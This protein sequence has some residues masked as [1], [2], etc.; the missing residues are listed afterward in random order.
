MLENKDASDLNKGQGTNRFKYRSFNSRVETL[1][2]DIVRR[3]RLV[4]DD[5]DENE[6]FF[7]DAL[8][9]WKDLNL[10][11]HFKEFNK[12]ILPLSKSL[13]SIVHH[14][15][16]IVDILEKHLLVKNS[17]ALDALLD[18]VTKLAKDLEGEFYP[19]YPRMLKCMLPLVYHQDVTLLECLFNSLAYLFK[20]LSRQ[21]IPDVNDTFDQLAKLL[22]ED[23][24]TK[25]YIRHFSAEAF[26]FLMRKVRADGLKKLVSH[27]LNSLD[28]DP[29]PQYVEGL[30]MLFFECMKQVDGCLHSRAV[31]IYT[32]LYIQT[33]QFDGDADMLASSA[34]YDLLRKTTLLVLHHTQRQHFTPIIKLVL[35]QTDS[36]LEPTKPDAKHLAIDMAV[37]A[38]ITTVRKAS[39]V[40]DFKPI[41]HRIQ[42]VTKLVFTGKPKVSSSLLCDE[43]LHAVT[44][45]LCFGSL[46]VV[47]SGGRLILDH[48]ASFTSPKE[49]FGFF[50]GLAELEWSN[51]CQ[52]AL[53]FITKCAARFIKSSPRET[54]YFLAQL[55]SRNALAITPG[56]M[57]ASVNSNGLLRFPSS[58]DKPLLKL[59]ATALDWQ[60]EL[61]TLNSFDVEDESAPA[62]GLATL[63]CV[64]TVLPAI[65]LTSTRDIFDAVLNLVDTLSDTLSHMDKTDIQSTPMVLGHT[66]F[67][68]T[69]LLGQTIH[70][71]AA[72]AQQDQTLISLLA[73]RHAFWLDLLNSHSQN[74]AVIKGIYVYLDLLQS[75]DK[76][77]DHFSLANLESVYPIIKTNLRSYQRNARLYSLK[78]LA[79]FD[80][81]LMKKDNDHRLDEPCDIVDVA[82]NMES[83]VPTLTDYRDKVILIQKINLISSAGRLPDIFDDFVPLVCFGL[84]T[85]NFKP[86]WDEARKTL[87]TFADVNKD[88]YWRM[89][90]D[91][92]EKFQDDRQLV[93][94]GFTRPVME[95]CYN[96]V[97]IPKGKATKTGNISF[98]CPNLNK[99]I[100]VEDHALAIMGAKINTQGVLLFVKACDQQPDHIDFWNY[101]NLIFKTLTETPAIV[102]QR[103]R[104]LIPLFFRFL[105]T[106]YSSLLTDDDQPDD[107]DNTSQQLG[108]VS[109]SIRTVK[110]KMVAWL[111]LLATF[112]NPR[113]LFRTEEIYTVLLRLIAKGD[114]RLQA[115]ALEALFTWKDRNVKPYMDNLRN[116]VDE[117]KFRD[118]LSTLLQNRDQEAI[119]PA[120]RNGLM[121]IIMRVLYGRFIERSGK[122]HNHVKK[123]RR[124]AILSAVAAC[125]PEEMDTFIHL[126]LEAFQ[127]IL[128]L[129]GDEFNEHD[130]L[131]SFVFDNDQGLDLMRNIPWRQQQGLVIA[132]EEMIKQLGATLAPFMHRLVKVV[133]Y[134]LHFAQ[135][136]TKSDDASDDDDM[137]VDE[138]QSDNE[139]NHD[140]ADDTAAAATSSSGGINSNRSRNIRNLAL[141]RLVELF[142]IK[143]GYDF[144]PYIP[145][146]FASFI[147]PRLAHF[148]DQSQ[149][150]NGLLSLFLEW[151]TQPA[152]LPF[153]ADH[154]A[155][156]LPQVYGI[157]SAQSL[158]R[159]VLETV[160][161]ILEHLLNYCDV[162][163]NDA[164]RK[165]R[166]V[167]NHI[168]S[169]LQYFLYR[170]TQSKDD[171]RFGS[172]YLSV[173][174]IALVAR[175]APFVKDGARTVMLL[176]ILIPNLKKPTRYIPEATKKHILSIWASFLP[177][178]PDFECGSRVY[179]NHYRRASELFSSIQS[180][181][182]RA[183]LMQVFQRFVQL[184]SQ[185]LGK[186]GSLLQ[187]M[188]SYSVKRIDEPDYDRILGALSEIGEDLYPTF[189]HHQWLPLLFQ[190]FHHM[191][192]REELSVRGTATHCVARFI[193]NVQA[194]LDNPQDCNQADVQMQLD[195]V[196][197]IIYPTI[198]HGMHS[199]AEAVRAEFVSLLDSCVKTMPTLPF[200]ASMTVLTGSG[201]EESNF[202]AN[203][204]HIQMHRRLRAM[205][206]LA[207]VADTGVL[208]VPSILHILLPLISGF[209]HEADRSSESNLIHH[210]VVTIG[211]LARHLPWGHYY[212]LLS[213][214]LSMVNR[215]E[216]REKMYVRLVTSVLDAFHFDISQVHVTDDM[217][218]KVMGKQKLTI[219]YLTHEEIVSNANKSKTTK[220]TK[221]A[222][223]AKD[224][225][226]PEGADADTN[227]NDDA[228]AQKE[229][230]ADGDAAASDDDTNEDDPETNEEDTIMEEVEE[231]EQPKD[232]ALKIHNVI[233]SKVLPELNAFIAKTKSRKSV[234]S[235]MPVA[236]GIAK[237]L[238]QL[239]EKTMVLN[240][241]GL[242]TIV[243]Q[244]TRSRADDVREIAR[245]TLI[246]INDF[247]G[248]Q[249]FKFIVKELVTALTKGY[250]LHVL[251]FTL[252]ALLNDMVPRLEVGDMNNS[253]PDV[254]K[255]LIG[256][257][258]GKAG[259]EKDAE[260]MT[261]KIMEAR[262][263]RSP[264]TFE[265]LAKIVTFDHLN[266][267]LL[268][269]KDI[270]TET[271]SIKLLKKVD[272][273]L[274]RISH[275]LVKNPGFESTDTLDF[276]RDLMAE[277]VDA[278]KAQKK[279]KA[280]KSQME[281]NY[282]VKTK[283]REVVPDDY[284][285]A[286]SHRFV[287]FGL[288]L[289]NTF[290]KRNKLD[291]TVDDYSTRLDAI[292]IVVGNVL[293]SAQT[294]NVTLASKNLC[295]L[296]R[297]PL[298]SVMDAVPVTIKRIFQLLKH[299]TGTQHPMVQ[300]CFKL[301]TVCIQTKK[302]N[303]TEHQLNYLLHLLR[304]DLE[305]PDRQGTAF[306]LVRAILARQFMAP[307]VYDLMDIV[308]TIFVT[309]QAPETREQA[310]S[311]YFAFLMD[312]PQGRGRLK[313]QMTFVLNNLEYVHE[314]GRV[315][316]MELLHH[317]ITKF[318]DQVLESFSQS[319]FMALV[320]RL[321]ND[322]SSKCRE[323][324]AELLKSLLD[325]MSSDE[326]DTIYRVLD[327]WIEADNANLQRAA[328]Q[329]YGLV[330][331][332]IGKDFKMAPQLIARL[333]VLINTGH[334]QWV[335]AL[336]AKDED[337]DMEVD[338]PWETT[339]YSLNTM[340]KLTTL[341]PKLT[342]ASDTAPLWQA[343][344]SLLLHPHAWIRSSTAR[345][346]GAYFAGV[347]AKQRNAYLTRSVL[348][349][350]A[351]GFSEQL[352]SS[353]LTEA[354]ATQLVKNLF[355]LGKCFYFLPADEDVADQDDH[356]NPE[357]A[358][359][360]ESDATPKSSLLWL[361]HRLSY[362]AR[363]STKRNDP[364]S[365][366]MRSSIFKWF[367]AM[368]NVLTEDDIPAYLYSIIAPL[369]HI[370]NTSSHKPGFDDL[371]N[372]ANEVLNLIQKKAG[373]TAYFGVYQNVKQH[374]QDVRDERKQQRSLEALQHPS[375]AAKR[376]MAQTQRKNQQ[377]KHKRARF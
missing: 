307:E 188:N 214:Y 115:A 7:F 56:A 141:H 340:S 242:L 261:G 161:T 337:D 269:L 19:Y 153:L 199:H 35:D 278:Y 8:Q 17:L 152:Y 143:G 154:D 237:L 134:I 105:D 360:P 173:R 101:F 182:A 168:D 167:Y 359:E 160:L 227:E 346:L 49:V 65:E 171:R 72:L 272:D 330:L 316:V 34:V 133:L 128:D 60:K 225:D 43:T 201:D 275:G 61:D 99:Y 77:A 26:A 320:M 212:R 157:L 370:V 22:G 2:V 209:L 291:L 54:V 259:Q 327:K 58:L 297:L 293:F 50:V 10:T 289:L 92:I 250:E 55:V 66:T 193:T 295:Q 44:G 74:P 164:N 78:L 196:K 169:L 30:A 283:R 374:A 329:V 325:R 1:K 277:N 254:V 176:D 265:L 246:K 339:Y 310:R 68:L 313:K 91:E 95:A 25:P 371:K 200:F 23:V 308:A 301:L 252:N 342:Y 71:L 215:N 27:I 326:L 185:Q 125:R 251:G 377:K 5:L 232:G 280:V 363:G 108:I 120:H 111:Q 190:L 240:L 158:D 343:I 195:Y 96:P 290:L 126:A 355:F 248:K 216:E 147:S 361:F 210:A 132:L 46:D 202:F 345:L 282:E 224:S 233:V 266:D 317:I 249:Y 76:K 162:P 268:P 333:S 314:S 32:E 122:S 87:K 238:R 235:R 230:A 53:A 336:A 48:I 264:A 98:E 139:D 47:V 260:G 220:A 356:V 311:V 362:T 331:D 373:P 375:L 149:H 67:A 369:Y 299:T 263:R 42:N 112:S 93:C 178:V 28:A 113:S 62:S 376:K 208:G 121:P 206:R 12:E 24:T 33:C 328:C 279:S 321:V 257:I 184:D 217:A 256:D 194:G 104:H 334:Q 348:R 83:I 226:E 18:L 15:D 287:H 116:L 150:V 29:S 354:Q 109:R 37:L 187:D 64:L 357:A 123:M 175:F 191:R 312:Y 9:S 353:F 223:P 192:N 350:L 148:S 103:A 39:R 286:N 102:E 16:K 79:L 119:D 114:H 243:C 137:E 138:D 146:M 318:G 205:A 14:K 69:S 332:V 81:P 180:R 247:L 3:S 324:A 222:K 179:L 140:A 127:P 131:E 298:P 273:L 349:D 57:N 338:V 156:L 231:P 204:Y 244:T 80:Q 124:K 11:R 211:A 309:N 236:L 170:L 106:E 258:F 296:Y 213:T 306:G 219:D 262:T 228:D 274:L 117:A 189:N 13:V 181:E 159:G 241:P 365:F 335:D 84:F 151:A 271:Q 352:K 245:D 367:A 300:A 145:A 41:L 372:L 174:Q 198:K 75:S 322:D 239:P 229:D 4:E 281:L 89:C 88:L 315:S 118:E 351:Y 63:S 368:A 45:V 107:Q 73:D 276:S 304:P 90:F 186:V 129:P 136:G 85:V 38:M 155:S 21:I 52:I 284:F 36:H 255:V 347:D 6:S 144:A 163:E 323:M 292:I 142:Q 40:Q 302:S 31:A 319:I 100:A 165:D 366:L 358:E 86:L 294:A 285:A 305:E 110:N 130:R 270:M 288:S 177:L 203:I 94:D 344:Q 303:L 183:M 341:F 59:L 207:E 234:I 218:T 166:L 20:F 97:H 253:M 197:T 135:N 82:L 267:L 172:G 70:T 364:A 221:D 51:F